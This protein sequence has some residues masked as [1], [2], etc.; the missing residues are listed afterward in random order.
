MTS[1][2]ALIRGGLVVGGS[3]RPG[4][5]T[6][7]GIR[8]GR[9][10]TIGDL[11]A[12]EAGQEIDAAGQVVAPGFIDLHTHSDLAHFV[13]PQAV[14]MD[15][16]PTNWNHTAATALLPAWAFELSNEEPS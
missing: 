2:D 16:M 12:A 4:A 11:S 5:V 6:D 15:M 10:A 9:I 3:G 1:F 13:D 8:G 14:A 7:V